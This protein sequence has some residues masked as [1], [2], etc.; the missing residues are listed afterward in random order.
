MPHVS[1][2][3]PLVSTEPKTG[4]SFIRRRAGFSLIELLTVIAVI[5]ILAAITT[6]VVGRVRGS[7]KKAE[8][9]SN[10]RQIGTAL[11]TY[12]AEYKGALPDNTNDGRWAWDVNY[13]IIQ[14]L[15]P[16]ASL[17]DIAYCPD[18]LFPE[19][20]ILW[21]GFESQ[22]YRAI[23]Y[24]LLLKGTPSLPPQVLNLKNTPTSYLDANGVRVT[25]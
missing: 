2:P 10:L 15:G 23:G 11:H 24:V 8:C 20:D 9:I 1:F 25:P 13:D 17:K 18:G 12:A 19:K 14:R 5:G 4:D 22:G 3:R 21:D 16:P 7:A 6:V